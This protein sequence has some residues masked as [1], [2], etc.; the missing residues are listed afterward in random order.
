MSTF[1]LNRNYELALPSSYVE[2]DNEEME[3]V[4]GGGTFNLTIQKKW[5]I[6]IG[7]GMVAGYIAGII[8]T[9]L[10]GGFFA[11]QA[12]RVVAAAVASTV[13]YILQKSTKVYSFSIWIPISG[14]YSKYFGF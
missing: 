3:Y 11:V 4:D 13:S 14:N 10:G 6:S 8:A 9:S 5:L 1:L 7:C 12:S 2:I